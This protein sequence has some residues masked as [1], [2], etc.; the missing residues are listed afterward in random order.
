MELDVPYVASPDHPLDEW[1]TLDCHV[2]QLGVQVA[3][4]EIIFLKPGGWAEKNGV[5]LDDEIASINGVE[6]GTM[7][8]T[9]KKMALTGQRYSKFASKSILN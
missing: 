1:Y 8:K 5:T 2:Q 7:S 9:Q 3:G 4:S 6:F